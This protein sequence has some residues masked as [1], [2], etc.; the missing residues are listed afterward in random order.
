MI[1]M[2]H[3]MI[4]MKPRGSFNTR[5]R[6]V[7]LAK[8]SIIASILSRKNLDSTYLSKNKLLIMVTHHAAV[9]SP[10]FVS[11]G[12]GAETEKNQK[13]TVLKFSTEPE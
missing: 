7:G 8:I 4:R 10:N 12:Q 1:A 9:V 3:W 6:L 5:H 2:N 13:R 11:V